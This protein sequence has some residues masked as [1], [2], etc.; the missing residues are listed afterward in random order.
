MNN[1]LPGTAKI[2]N[3]GFR[4]DV[5]TTP[6]RMSE[7]SITLTAKLTDAEA[8]VIA[9]AEIQSGTEDPW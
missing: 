4:L 7:K 1:A 2:L 5:T 9:L 6:S 3:G 8:L